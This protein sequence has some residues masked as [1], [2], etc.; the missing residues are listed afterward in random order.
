[1]ETWRMPSDDDPEEIVEIHPSVILNPA[2]ARD[3][4]IAGIRD[5]LGDLT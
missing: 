3:K 4:I 1:M 2:N 5:E